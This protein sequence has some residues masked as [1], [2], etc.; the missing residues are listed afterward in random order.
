MMQVYGIFLS[1]AGVKL[2]EFNLKTVYG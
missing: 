2:T 1:P